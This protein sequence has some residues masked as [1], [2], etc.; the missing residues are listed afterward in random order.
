MIGWQYPSAVLCLL[1]VEHDYCVMKV[2]VQLLLLV[3]SSVNYTADRCNVCP[4]NVAACG[5]H[6]LFQLRYV[7]GSSDT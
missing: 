2:S 3:D 4:Y 7:C 5:S 6:V 1:S